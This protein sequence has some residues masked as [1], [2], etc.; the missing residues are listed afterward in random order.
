MNFQTAIIELTELGYTQ[1]AIA[2]EC[3]CAKS[4]ITEIKQGVI[5][6]PSFDLGYKLAE[7]HKKAVAA[8]RRKAARSAT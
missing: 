7:M 8:A 5:T 4:T 6:R 3:G 1:T 2:A